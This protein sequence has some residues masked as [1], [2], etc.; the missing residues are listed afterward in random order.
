MDDRI[1]SIIN[2]FQRLLKAD[3]TLF[4]AKVIKDDGDTCDV[5][6]MTDTEY[7][8]VRKIATLERKGINIKIK[9][10]SYVLVGR[11]SGAGS[12]ELAVLMYS[13]IE[14]IAITGNVV[15]NEGENGGVPIASV[16]MDNLNAIKK[17]L[18]AMNNAIATALPATGAPAG[19]A[20]ASTYTATMSAQQ[21]TFSAIEN[22]KVKH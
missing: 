16:V 6:D 21:L 8:E 13:E 4:L 7:K 9:P 10:Q 5:L 19:A 22:E 18:T 20:A 2:G 3:A 11:L 17:Y 12:N 15:I 1:Q 14:E